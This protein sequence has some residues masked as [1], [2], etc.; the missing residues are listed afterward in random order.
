MFINSE[1]NVN[2]NNEIKRITYYRYNNIIYFIIN[3]VYPL[4]ETLKQLVNS[5]YIIY[6]NVDIVVR[7]AINNLMLYIY[8]YI[9]I[10]VQF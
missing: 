1:I 8:I 7:C 3:T 10:L 2:H 5:N 6:Y 4:F 9:Y